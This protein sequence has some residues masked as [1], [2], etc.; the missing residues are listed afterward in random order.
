VPLNN[1]TAY[2]FLD[3]TAVIFG[4]GGTFSL[5]GADT[6]SAEEGLTIAMSED[7]DTMRIG[8]DGSPMHQLN[9]NN[10]G[11]LTIRLL[12]TS[13]VNFLLSAMY[14][15]QRLSS[16]N[17]GQNVIVVREVA[18]GDFITAQ[19]VAFKKW[20][21]LTFAK[22]AGNNEWQ[23]NCGQIDGI[24]GTGTPSQPLI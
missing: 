6:G 21:D 9:A 11:T 15:F 23:F 18:T 16:A 13:P 14:D 10:S 4:P 8:A 17:W 1:L 12:K 3:V 19:S 7:K 24:L 5:S 20:P 2:S 22:D